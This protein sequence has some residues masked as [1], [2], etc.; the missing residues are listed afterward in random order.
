[1]S[2]LLGLIIGGVQ[3][4]FSDGG[5]LWIF[6]GSFL[7][8]VVCAIP[9]ISSS[10]ATSILLPV[11]FV[12]TPGNAMIFLTSIYIAST[13]GSSIT[14]ILL[15]TPGSP[16]SAATTIDGHQMTLKGLGCEALGCSFGASLLGGMISYIVMIFA[17]IPIAWFAVKIGSPELFLLSLLGISVLGSL[18]TENMP[19]ILLSG[20]IGLLIGTI[21]ITPTGEWRGT[22]NSMFLA[23]GVQ[24]IP[25]IIGFFAF[26]E[27][28]T[29]I[30][31][32]FIVSSE[33]KMEKSLKRILK[34]MLLPFKYPAT[35]I[36]SSIIGIIIGIIPAAGGTVASFTSYVEA[37]RSSKR[38]KYF[39][40][41]E[42]EG[43]VAPESANNADTG[44]ALMTT[45][46]LG[47]PGGSTCAIILGAL[48]LQGLRP[49]PQLVRDQMPLVYLIIM[50]AILS[51]VV[52]LAMSTAAGYWLTSLLTVSTRILGPVVAVCCMIGTF[53]VRNAIFD[54]WLMFAFGLLGYLMKEYDFSLPGI[55]LGVVLGSIADSELIRTYMRFG[56]DFLLSFVTRPISIVFLSLVLLSILYPIFAGLFKKKGDT[57]EES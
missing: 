34:G 21:G 44:G 49:G 57:A 3:G 37:K 8:I 20:F 9:G 42:P 30:D 5:F 14:A 48:M 19:K 15:N 17:M 41:G 13:Y 7:G 11:T 32:D 43:I 24:V 38:G 56:D 27:V 28:L 53:A 31:Q 36:K 22:F 16:E 45:L 46:A 52:M 50:S 12:L 4:V 10:M 25:A 33:V 18:S 35:L 47:I 26:S 55:T 54:V 1:M 6:V 23:D 29:M 40:T 51:Q 39:G 2:E